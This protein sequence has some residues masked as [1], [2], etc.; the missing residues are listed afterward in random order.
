MNVHLTQE[1]EH[2]VQSRVK[3][4]RYASAS[5]VVR[6]ALRLLADRD[7]MMELRK[8]ELRT[9]IAQGLDSLQRGE[10][11]DGDEFFAQLE[12]EESAFEKPPAA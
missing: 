11:V 1:L 8:Q 4:G 10:G 7:E 12:R 9:K 5:E 2:L 3:S 6:D